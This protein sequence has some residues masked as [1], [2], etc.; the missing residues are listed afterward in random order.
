MPHVEGQ[1]R[2]IALD[3]GTFL[4]P[5]DER[6]HREGVP[7]IMDARQFTLV[8]THRSGLEKQPKGAMKSGST[9]GAQRSTMSSA[10]K[11]RVRMNREFLPSLQQIR[12][13][14]TRG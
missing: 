5:T 4:I 13:Q 7:Q 14:L 11:R 8:V 9:V 1:F 6:L 12:P 2:Q 3:V 10:E